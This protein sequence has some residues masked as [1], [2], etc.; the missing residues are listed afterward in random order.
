MHERPP[1]RGEPALE[2]ERV[3]GGEEH[4]GNG[5]GVVEA[6]GCRHAQALALVHGELLGVAATTRPA[7][8]IPGISTGAG[9]PG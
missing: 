8:S 6:N 2:D 9:G 7:N 4:L 1:A 5:G 3:P